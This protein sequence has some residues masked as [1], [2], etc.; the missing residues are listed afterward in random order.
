MDNPDGSDIDDSDALI[1]AAEVNKSVCDNMWLEYNLITLTPDFDVSVYDISDTYKISHKPMCKQ[2]NIDYEREGLNDH[3][4]L[5]HVRAYDDMYDTNM[6][7]AQHG[8]SDLPSESIVGYMC[9]ACGKK[10]VVTTLKQLRSADEGA[11]EIRVC[12]SCMLAQ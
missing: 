7:S 4:D 11:T 9:K 2:F 1:C 12:M 3:I 10:S 8:P 6:F 5:S